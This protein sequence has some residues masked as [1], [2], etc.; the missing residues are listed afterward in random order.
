MRSPAFALRTLIGVAVDVLFLADAASIQTAAVMAC[1]RGR[2]DAGRAVASGVV[3]DEGSD[4]DALTGTS[5]GGCRE[6]G[7]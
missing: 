5:I 6:V 7:E 3:E 1:S 2:S 4:L